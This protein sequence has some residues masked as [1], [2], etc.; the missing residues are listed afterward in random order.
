MA[1]L[2]VNVNT[3]I[4]KQQLLKKDIQ[5][6]WKAVRGFKK[7][8]DLRTVLPLLP[9]TKLLGLA[10]F[11]IGVLLSHIVWAQGKNEV[12]FSCQHSLGIWGFKFCN[13]GSRELAGKSCRLPHYFRG[14]LSRRQGPHQSLRS[15]G[16]STSAFL[17]FRWTVRKSCLEHT[18]KEISGSLWSNPGRHLTFLLTNQSSLV[19][20]LNKTIKPLTVS[21]EQEGARRSR[22]HDGDS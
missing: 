2:K 9:R 4:I 8:S 17:K 15:P 21:A 1:N 6:Q 16:G 5:L 22:L 12:F 3:H 14:F 18:R 7:K 11:Q 13:W 20:V 19:H 10:S